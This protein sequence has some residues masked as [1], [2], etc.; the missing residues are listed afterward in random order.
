MRVL[1]DCSNWDSL[2]Q[3]FL[4]KC[5]W[6]WSSKFVNRFMRPWI[7]TVFA[8]W[9]Q[10]SG[11]FSYLNSQHIWRW[12]IIHTIHSTDVHNWRTNWSHKCPSNCKEINE[13]NKIHNVSS[14][15]LF[16]CLHQP[17]PPLLLLSLLCPHLILLH[18][19]L[20]KQ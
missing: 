13:L 6:V 4:H 7:L 3:L 16:W 9:F 18:E 19:D 8:I 14:I 1:P 5:L 2:F 11:I 12:L 20:S 17:L 15:S 10:S